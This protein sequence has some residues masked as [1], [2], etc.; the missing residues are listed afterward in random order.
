V[1]GNLISGRFSLL[2]VRNC[3][4]ASVLALFLAALVAYPA[5]GLQRLAGAV[6][7]LVLV[8]FFNL[9]RIMSV[10]FIGITRPDVVEFVHWQ[11]WPPILLV[12]A[13]LSFLAWVS[14]AERP[15][16]LP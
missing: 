3:D 14:W 16:R 2:I 1:D 7:G 9:A 4:A 5:K 8:F 12:M 10:Y 11:V 15:A 13:A 6:A